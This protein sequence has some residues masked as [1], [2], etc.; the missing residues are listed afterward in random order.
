VQP[1]LLHG[2]VAKN[3]RE[4]LVADITYIQVAEGFAYLFLVTDAYSRMIVGYHLAKTLAHEGAVI[5]LKTALKFIPE[6]Q[7]VIHHSDRGIQ[8]CCHNFLEEARRY[9]FRPSMTDADHCAQNALAESMNGI[10]KGEFLLDHQFPS[11]RQAQLALDD[12]I[13]T[14]NHLRG[15][16]SLN[17]KTPAELHYGHDGAFELW[18]KEL[19]SFHI[20]LTRDTIYV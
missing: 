10:L 2:V 18:A 5:A 8:Y 6:P 12:A 13:F 16:G 4:V 9:G 19:L 15:H 11:F 7:G 20:P 14:Y 1:N 17:G 3:P